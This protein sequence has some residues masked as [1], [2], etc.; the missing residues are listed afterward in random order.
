MILTS[1]A[2]SINLFIFHTYFTDL[3]AA[4][5][6]F[7]RNEQIPHYD[8]RNKKDLHPIKIKTKLYGEK[9]VS[10]EGRHCWNK[11]PSNVKEISSVN[12]FKKKTQTAFA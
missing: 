1:A 11:L 5:T 7:C 3:D 4:N 8:T 10:F 2:L 6:T 9:T 12:L